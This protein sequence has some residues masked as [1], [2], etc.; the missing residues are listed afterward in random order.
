VFAAAFAPIADADGPVL[1]AVSGGP[2]SI[3]LMHALAAWA[4]T[5]GG[6][7]LQVA[8]VDHG[9]RP[10]SRDEAA[11]VGG[12]A[13]ALGLAHAVLPWADRP[14]EPISQDAARRAR[15][16][17]LVGHA[18]LVG[19]ERLLTAHTL[20]DQAETVLMR[21]AAGSGLTGLAGMAGTGRTDGIVH[22]RPFLGILKARLVATCLA[23]GWPFVEDP[24][25]ADERF[26]RARWRRLGP[27]L[28]AEGL[29]PER[30]A[31]LAGRLARA[32]AALDGAAAAAAARCRLGSEDAWDAG[33][34]AAEPAEI[35][36]RVL[37]KALAARPG[38][39]RIR[40]ERLEACF[41]ALALAQREGRATRRTLAGRA[42]SLDREGRLTIEQERPRRRGSPG[43]AA[44]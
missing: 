43:S 20:D 19:A 41:E 1:L 12:Q 21:L 28:A 23:R 7:P 24:S 26:A 40:L 17:L 38:G 37:L 22:L 30:L 9:L 34:L 18:H 32:D 31:R 16:R 11:A 13:A 42:L 2:D 33:A 14:R 36:L 27:A 3:A 29:G 8:T 4:G 15:Y 6:P 44:R 35:G 5:R 10:G 25:N 39:E